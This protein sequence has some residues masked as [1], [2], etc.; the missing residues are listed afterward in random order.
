MAKGQTSFLYSFFLIIFYVF[1][2]PSSS[3]LL[4][5]KHISSSLLSPRVKQR[6]D[7][8]NA[9]ILKLKK[10]K[11]LLSG[12]DLHFLRAWITWQGKDTDWKGLH[13][14]VFRLWYTIETLGLVILNVRWRYHVEKHIL[15]T[16]KCFDNDIFWI[17]A[18]FENIYCW[19]LE[20]TNLHSHL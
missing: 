14:C 16:Y 5:P 7:K 9:V 3:W 13:V 15:K 11:T 18:I 12:C 20:T 8:N 17:I 4:P 10:E 6:G 1:Q 2:S 19:E